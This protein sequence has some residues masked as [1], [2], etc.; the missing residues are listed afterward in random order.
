MP[1]ILLTVLI[2]MLAIGLV[3]P[4]LPRLV[5]GFST[6][7]ARQVMDYAG[8]TMAF[9]IANFLGA[10][11]MGA[12]SDRFGRRPVL[13]AGLSGLALSFF[14]TAAASA[15]WILVAVRLVS[16][17][18]QANAAVAA[19]Y[20]ADVSA[21]D[22]RPRRYGQVGAMVGIGFI[23]GLLVGG[24][25]SAIDLR[26][27]FEAAGVLATCNVLYGWLILP[28][29]LSPTH[30]QPLSWAKANP[31]GAFAHLAM[32]SDMLPWLFVIACTALTQFVVQTTWVLF[33][34]FKFG[35]SPAETG[36]SLSAIGLMT[37]LVQGVLVGSLTRAMSTAR[38]AVLGSASSALG[39]LAWGLATQGWMLYAVIVVNVLGFAAPPALQSLISQRAGPAA[40]G[41]TFGAVTG[42]S[43]LMAVVAPVF[44][45]LLLRAVAGASLKGR[46][47]QPQMRCNVRATA[48]LTGRFQ[49]FSGCHL[50]TSSS[51]SPRRL[52]ERYGV[53]LQGIID[54]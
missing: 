15:L 2:D 34:Q 24:M 11:L 44:G 17:A 31:F 16:G 50:P 18:T 10:P 40:Q 32:M 20:V 9:G 26:L 47:K 6:V 3:V 53:L 39:L 51:S 38:L 45:P 23:L 54:T 42:L 12:L 1:F 8:V 25:L 22:E 49:R 7:P 41:R 37:V 36:W 21:P 48:L 46:P 5:A 33:T 28:E 13:L 14:V 43:G 29:S 52:G 35:W 4:V 19:A 30:R 27:P